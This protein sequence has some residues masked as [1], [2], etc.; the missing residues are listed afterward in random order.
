MIIVAIPIATKSRKC[1]F[2]DISLHLKFP[3][4]EQI[5]KLDIEM[6]YKYMDI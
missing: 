2:R 5:C 4:I 6:M 1:L 3:I